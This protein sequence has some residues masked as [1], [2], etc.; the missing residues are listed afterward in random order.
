MLLFADSG[1]LTPVCRSGAVSRR[2]GAKISFL[3]GA[4][5]IRSG[6]PRPTVLKLAT[7][8][9]G[10]ELPFFFLPCHAAVHDTDLHSD[11]LNHRPI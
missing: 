8:K 3:V 2:I 10:K 6:C 4:G 11:Q 9:K 1:S 7:K 5:T